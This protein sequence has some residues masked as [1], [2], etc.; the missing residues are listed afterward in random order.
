MKKYIDLACKHVKAGSLS[1][2][3]AGSLSV[4]ADLPIHSWYKGEERIRALKSRL[5]ARRILETL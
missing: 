1:P 4:E 3:L 2:A 5:S